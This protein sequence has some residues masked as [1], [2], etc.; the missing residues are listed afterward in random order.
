MLVLSMMLKLW[1]DSFWGLLIFI[2][3]LLFFLLYHMAGW[4]LVHQAGIEPVP[5]AVE[6]GSPNRWPIGEFPP[7][8]YLCRWLNTGFC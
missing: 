7:Q 3:L 1:I 2:L 5:P 4:I 8:S 6:A